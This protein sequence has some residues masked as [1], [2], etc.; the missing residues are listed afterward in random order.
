MPSTDPGP[1]PDHAL[2]DAAS[3]LRDEGASLRARIVQMQED[4]R[5]V[6][7]SSR[8]SNA[9]D[10]HDPEGQTIAFERSQLAAMTN[11]ARAHLRD[12]DAALERLADGTYGV[13]EVCGQPIPAGRLEARPTARTCVQHVRPSAP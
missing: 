3:R 13:C 6:I 10:E 11:Q 8:D 2:A 4:M 7:E 12:V 9:D 1:G 5:V